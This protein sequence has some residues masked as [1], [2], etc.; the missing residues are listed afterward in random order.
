MKKLIALGLMLAMVLSAAACGSKAPEEPAQSEPA[1]EAA[2]EPAKAPEESGGDKEI[3]IGVVVNSL[4]HVYF[5]RIKAAMEAEADA[6]GVKLELIDGAGDSAVQLS[7][8][9]DFIAEEVDAICVAFC[10]TDGSSSMVELAN[11]AGI[12]FFTFD[13]QADGGEV[14]S[15]CATDNYA[16]GQLA[17]QY[18]LENILTDKTGN[19]VIIPYDEVESC[20][21]R[22][23]GFEDY[24]K[25]NAPDITVES[26]AS[27]SGDRLTAYSNFQ[28]ALT[29]I[30]AEN[31]DFVFGVGDDA[32]LGAITACE[33]ANVEIPMI[34]L[35]GNPEAEKNVAAG[36]MFKADVAQDAAGIGKT[37]IDN[38]VAYLNGETVEAEVLITPTM[39]TPENAD[40]N[41]Q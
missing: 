15:Y 14:V 1:T 11:N 16:G 26:I 20:R 32:V 5:N 22:A 19:C 38:V 29:S 6:L 21:N 2:E 4:E 23:K 30:G 8:V 24:M 39:I 37:T 17:A 36:G 13:V 25:E 10:Q 31:I 18:C 12:P 9:Q 35:D 34:G 27:F 28:D 7:A 41:A 33:E 40:P 3:T